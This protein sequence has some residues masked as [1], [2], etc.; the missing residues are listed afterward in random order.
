M[1]EYCYALLLLMKEGEGSLMLQHVPYSSISSLLSPPS[2]RPP[3][4]SSLHMNMSKLWQIMKD[5]GYPG[6]TQR[7]IREFAHEYGAVVEG[8]Y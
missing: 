7:W 6:Y 4:F 1:Q 2:L 5:Q 3:S 8:Q